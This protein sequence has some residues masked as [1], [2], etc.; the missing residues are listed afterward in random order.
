[1]SLSTLLIAVVAQWAALALFM[2]GAWAVQ[3]RTANA[4]YIDAVWTFGLGLV[5]IVS[6]LMPVSAGAPSGRQWLIAAI[7]LAWSLRLASTS[8]G[9]WLRAATTRAMRR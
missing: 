3:Q 7:M 4:G 5:G 2:T 9:A 8:C 1:M 6:A